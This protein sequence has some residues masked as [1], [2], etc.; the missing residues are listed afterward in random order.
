MVCYTDGSA[1]DGHTNGGAG[2]HIIHDQRMQNIKL[3]GGKYTSSFQA[4]MIAL[5]EALH[6]FNA[7]QFANS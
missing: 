5:A 7:Q 4:E 1:I 6:Q 2:M 3:P